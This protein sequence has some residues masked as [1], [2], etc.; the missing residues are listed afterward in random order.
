MAYGFAAV[1]TAF[2]RLTGSEPRAPLDAVRMARHYMWYDCGKAARE[3]GYAPVP[4]RQALARAR[5]MLEFIDPR[6]LIE[7]LPELLEMLESTCFRIT[8]AVTDRYFRHEEAVA[9]IIE[10]GL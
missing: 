2:S 9:W 3:L 7:Q 6:Q 5:G 4:A 10:E 8:D 1:D